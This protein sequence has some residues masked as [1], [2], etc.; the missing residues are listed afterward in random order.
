[1][2]LTSINNQY[3]GLNGLAGGYSG[4]CGGA[5]GLYSDANTQ[6]VKN[7]IENAYEISATSNSYANKSSVSSSS[8]TQQCQTIQYL[9]EQGRTDEAMTKYEQLYNDMAANPYYEGYGENEIKTLLQE[10]YMS[11]T[12]SS[13]VNAIENNSGSSFTTSLSSSIPVL[14]LL[15]EGKSKDDFIS[16]VTGTG[17]S[18]ASVAG[19]VAGTVAGAATSA[20]AGVLTSIAIGAARGKKTGKVGMIVGGI[21]GAAT[22]LLT[23]LTNKSVKSN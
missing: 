18:K 21:I 12:G 17:A 3:L 11:A 15:T 23:N 8:F 4:Y 2:S 16:E 9:L 6:T 5:A 14:G 7:N 13:L 10:Q 20:G 19:S 22:S 1:M